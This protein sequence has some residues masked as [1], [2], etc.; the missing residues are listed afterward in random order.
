MHFNDIASSFRYLEPRSTY[1]R[2]GA[3][4]FASTLM[5]VGCGESDA[6][7]DQRAQ[8]E[9]KALQA[10]AANINSAHP[11]EVMVANPSDSHATISLGGT[12]I[13]KTELTIRAQAP[14]RVVYIAGEE[15][16]AVRRGQTIVDLDEK[17]LIAQRSAA[18]AGRRRAQAQLRNAYIQLDQNIISD[19]YNGRGGMGMPSMFDYFV[20]QNMG[21][22]AGIGDSD[23]DRYAS[24]SSSRNA[25]EQA[26]SAVLE[27]ESQLDQIDAMFRDKQAIAPADTIILEK[28]IEL[29]DAVQ[30]GQSLVRIG[31][32]SALQV[33]I[34]VPSRL[35][36]SLSEDMDIDVSIDTTNT[37]VKGKIVRIF[38]SA[39]A[40]RHTV[41][42]KIS[43]P[44]KTNASP[45]MYVNV[46]VPDTSRVGQE[47]ISLPSSAIVWRG[48]QSS[49]YM[50]NNDG[51]AELRM[52]R[53]A[54]AGA[55]ES[56]VVLSGI[57]SGDRIVVKPDSQ[58][59]SGQLIQVLSSQPSAQFGSPASPYSTQPKS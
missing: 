20:T 34:D 1:R 57:T 24:I 21:D 37:R 22:A 11:Y 32:I 50:V 26:K 52:V 58:I 46:E 49:V 35:L 43:L 4:V 33:Q 23:Y 13:P 8:A 16:T 7:K 2:L 25:V 29:G 10:T 59:R 28:M 12:V 53:T 27:A 47:T 31:D 36:T 54:S 6:E 18:D 9:T 56:I 39:D 48:S 45:G 41:R 38:P 44:P 17:S 30:P 51:K 42:V 5:L 3:L 15:G 55:G 19:G 14:G 40:Q